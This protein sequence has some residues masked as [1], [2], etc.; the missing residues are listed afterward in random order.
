[1]AVKFKWYQILSLLFAFILF[2]VVSLAVCAIA[3]FAFGYTKSNNMRTLLENREADIPSQVYDIEGR[4]IAELVGEQKRE[5]VYFHELPIEIV[6][7]LISREDPGFFYHSGFSLRSTLRAVLFLGKRGGGSTISQQASGVKFCNRQERTINRKIKELWFSFN[8]E[9]DLSKEEIVQLYLNEVYFGHSAYGIEAASQFFFKH[10]AK[11]L[12]LAESAIIVTPISNPYYFSPIRYRDTAA[13]RQKLTLERM[14]SNGYITKETADEAYSEFWNNFDKNRS[15]DENYQDITSAHNKA[16]YFTDYIQ[17]QLQ[18]ILTGTANIYKDGYIIETSLNLDWQM[19]AQE[20]IKSDMKFAEEVY[21]AS[22]QNQGDTS[23]RRY[24]PIV[25]L[26]CFATNIA[27]IDNY[28]ARQDRKARDRYVD[29]LSPAL[30][31]VS[32]LTGDEQAHNICEMTNSLK[33][34]ISSET[35]IQTSLIS[36]E[37][38]TGRIVA[39]IGGRGYES[40]FESAIFNRATMGKIQPGSAIKPL[41]YSAGISTRQITPATVFNDSPVMFFEKGAD[42]YA[43]NNYMDKW[44]GPVRVRYSLA[45]SLNIPSI[46]ILELVGYDIAITRMTDLLGLQ[47]QKNNQNLW[48][49]KLPIALGIVQVSPLNMARAYAVFGNDGVGVE[50]HGI[51]SI[52]DRNGNPL[53]QYGTIGY[54]L[55]KSVKAS[56]DKYRILTSQ[57][58]Y[59][60]VDLLKSTVYDRYGLL[61]G[62]SSAYNFFDGMPMAGK[63]GTTQNWEDAWAVG[64]SPYL[65]TAV[66]FGFDSGSQSL[67]SGL[68]GASLSARSWANFMNYAHKNKPIK[69]FKTPADGIVEASVCAKTGLL[70]TQHCGLVISE[71]FLEGTI[72]TK[73]CTTCKSDAHY[74]EVE[75]DKIRFHSS[76]KGSTDSISS[77]VDLFLPSIDDLTKSAIENNPGKYSTLEEEILREENEKY[78][79]LP[80]FSSGDSIW[81]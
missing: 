49:R 26:I 20:A 44:R 7:A 41:Y 55:E 66:W 51:L 33:V 8:L 19:H 65:T 23:I 80:D 39:M 34:Q 1:M 69:E 53:G 21:N 77:Q 11:E 42:P 57:E 3:G 36:I 37:N 30:S 22:Q 9:R 6:T 71:R 12:T 52:K 38:D 47:H 61:Y 73:Y 13:A 48:P 78:L 45:A 76:I 70:P 56:E 28:S 35:E 4:L 16:P 59:I 10:P 63:T 24:I 29:N 14:I 2:V 54:D 50:P 43:P 75:E 81:D 67:G 72:P 17:D 74:K 31:I 60:M 64:F 27:G 62:R 18:S 46:Q 58:N 25:D 32:L 15:P 5:I 40:Q 79:S 68:T